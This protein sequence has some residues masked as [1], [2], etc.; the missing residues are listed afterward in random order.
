MVKTLFKH[1]KDE[2]EFKLH[3]DSKTTWI[4]CKRSGRKNAQQF[5]LK[6]GQSFDE[7]QVVYIEEEK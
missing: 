6:G 7:S 1:I 4:K 2:Q 5:G 3:P